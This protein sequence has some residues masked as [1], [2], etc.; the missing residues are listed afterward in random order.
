L[1]EEARG[2]DQSFFRDPGNQTVGNL[3]YYGITETTW[4]A[5]PLSFPWVW[6]H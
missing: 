4:A 2:R 3:K 1:C 6:R 5:V